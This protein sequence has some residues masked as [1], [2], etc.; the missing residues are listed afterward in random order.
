MWFELLVAVLASWQ[1]V[2]T[3]ENGSLFARIRAWADANHERSLVAELLWCMFCFSHHPPY[4]LWIWIFVAWLY[5]DGV[6]Y[7]MQIVPLWLATTRL[8]QLARKLAEPDEFD[9]VVIDERIEREN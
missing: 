1:V 6:G 5:R 9:S 4:L 8:V 3:Y 7:W 2:E